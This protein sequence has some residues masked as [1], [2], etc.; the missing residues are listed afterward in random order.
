MLARKRQYGWHGWLVSVCMCDVID[1]TQILCC[2]S[3]GSK[4]I[5]PSLFVCDFWDFFI[6]LLVSY[7]VFRFRRTLW[8]AVSGQ[9]LP[10][11][12]WASC[13]R[14]GLLL[15]ITCLRFQNTLGWMHMLNAFTQQSMPMSNFTPK[16]ALMYSQVEGRRREGLMWRCH[17]S[18]TH[19]SPPFNLVSHREDF[20]LCTTSNRPHSTIVWAHNATLTRPLV[21]LESL[22]SAVVRHK[23]THV[24]TMDHS[25]ANATPLN[26]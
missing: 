21:C 20:R 10:R 6:H 11:S 3:G 22:A 7:Q 8:S 14:T 2:S 4:S 23:T 16:D 5:W 17:H 19:C 26:S 9:S 1:V 12:P 24:H 15:E 25:L 13:W 18:L